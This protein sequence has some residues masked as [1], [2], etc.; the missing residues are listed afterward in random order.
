MYQ[1]IVFI[2][3]TVGIRRVLQ[4]RVPEHVSFIALK[5]YTHRAI[6]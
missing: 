2:K 1:N 5:A 4:Y 6:P 3:G